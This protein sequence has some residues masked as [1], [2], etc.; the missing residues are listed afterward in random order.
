[1]I[2][3]CISFSVKFEKKWCTEVQAS[4]T[5][6]KTLNLFPNSQRGKYSVTS[7]Q[8]E[9]QATANEIVDLQ[10]M[11]FAIAVV[12]SYGKLFSFST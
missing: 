9:L 10:N 8:V 1:M 2:W 5:Q 11:M 12:E 4:A 3:T 6:A 7:I